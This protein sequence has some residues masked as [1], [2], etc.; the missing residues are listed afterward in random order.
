MFSVDNKKKVYSLYGSYE[1]RKWNDD[2]DICYFNKKRGGKRFLYRCAKKARYE[3]LIF[4]SSL[5]NSDQT[6]IWTEA[7][8]R[9]SKELLLYT[10]FFS[11]AEI[12]NHI[13][14]EVQVSKISILDFDEI[15]R[16]D[17]EIFE[18]YWRSSSLTLLDTLKSCRDVYLYSYRERSRII[19][20]A[21]VGI[22]MR[23]SFL[24]RFAVHPKKQNMG[25]GSRMLEFVMN[26]MRKK[27]MISMRL[28]TQ[29]DNIVAQKLYKNKKF[30]LSNQKLAIMTSED[31]C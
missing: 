27:K 17:K 1:T 24:Q 8:W 3:K 31:M 13:G 26:D 21:I 18:P 20:Y 2:V 28:N 11:V 15:V 6:K 25:L 16:L 9:V 30:S 22:T 14:K 29:P 23:S 19:S 10:H 12:N 5:V 7:G 4:N